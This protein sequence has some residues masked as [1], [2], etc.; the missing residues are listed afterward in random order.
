[1][2]SAEGR[3]LLSTAISNCREDSN[4][5]G[6]PAEETDYQAQLAILQSMFDGYVALNSISVI[7]SICFGIRKSK[8]DLVKT[9]EAQHT[10]RD[11]SALE[12]YERAVSALGR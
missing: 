2:L 12:C 3:E 1:M 5:Q 7:V 6:N 11:D 10:G 9:T 4:S 8:L